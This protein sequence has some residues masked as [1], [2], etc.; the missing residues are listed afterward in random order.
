MGNSNVPYPYAIGKK[1]TY[2]MLEC[3]YVENSQL[4]D[5]VDP[6]VWFYGNRKDNVKAMQKHQKWEKQYASR[7]SLPQLKVLHERLL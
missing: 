4:D 1:Y 6:Y 7:H 2:L 3:I 5:I